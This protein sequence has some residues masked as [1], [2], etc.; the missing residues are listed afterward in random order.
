MMKCCDTNWSIQSR[1]RAREKKVKSFDSARERNPRFS[2]PSN[3]ANVLPSRNIKT[4]SIT[5]IVSGRGERGRGDGGAKVSHNRDFMKKLLPCFPLTHF[6]CLGFSP[7]SISSV[8]IKTKETFL[9]LDY[10]K[11]SENKM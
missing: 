9:L 7:S 3:N 1:R 6:V 11:Q 4:L 5:A 2:P 8:G 10:G